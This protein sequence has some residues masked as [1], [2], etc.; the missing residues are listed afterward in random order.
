MDDELRNAEPTQHD[1][2]SENGCPNDRF[3][4]RFREFGAKTEAYDLGTMPVLLVLRGSFSGGSLPVESSARSRIVTGTT[5]RLMTR[6]A[7]AIGMALSPPNRSPR[8]AGPTNGTA[9]AEAVSACE[10]ADA[11]LHAKDDAGE[12]KH[13]TVETNDGDAQGDDQRDVLTECR[14]RRRNGSGKKR[15]RHGVKQHHPI[16]D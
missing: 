11:H 14:A 5:V 10:R 12:Q 2:E 3:F 6:L 9:G 4:D 16:Q 13:R 1:N 7:I 8:T 15:Q